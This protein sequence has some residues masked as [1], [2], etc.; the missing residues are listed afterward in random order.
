MHWIEILEQL[1]REQTKEYERP[2][3]E[4]PLPY[5][6]D[7]YNIPP[8][9]KTE[10]APAGRVIIIDMFEENSIKAGSSVK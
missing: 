5:Y 4:L 8:P 2:R 9:G 7:R 3:L 10:E 6:D 1:R